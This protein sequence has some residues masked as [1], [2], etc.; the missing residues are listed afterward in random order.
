[1]AAMQNNFM[2]QQ[3]LRRAQDMRRLTSPQ[4]EAPRLELSPGPP[5]APSGGVPALSE[6]L[7]ELLGEGLSGDRLLIAALIF[8]LLKEGADKSLVLA[9]GYI[10]L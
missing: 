5:P 8:L 10:M 1:M 3:A 6:K 4:E 9:L 7:R 2:R